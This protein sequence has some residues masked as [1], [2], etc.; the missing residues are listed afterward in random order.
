MTRRALT[1]AVVLTLAVASRAPAQELNLATTS[2]ARPSVVEVRTGMDHALLAELAYYRVVALGDR[3]LLVGADAAMPWAK[4]DL[5]DYRLR[6]TAGMP[7]GG[8]HWKIAGWLSPTVRGTRNAA[9]DM[10]AVGA[11]VRLTGGYYARRWFLA[12]ETG[13]D[14]IAATHVAFSDA[15]TSRVYSGARDGWYRMPGGTAYAGLHGGVSFRSF[16]VVLRAGH[17]RTT[18]LE[19][20]TVPFYLTVGVNV[21]LPR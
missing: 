14:W 5:G 4:A 21:A 13:V 11:D 12:G 16:D 7:F 9:S 6:A 17:P 15:Y 2:T 3:Q 8:E 20:Q 1:A 19:Q 10:A 18:D